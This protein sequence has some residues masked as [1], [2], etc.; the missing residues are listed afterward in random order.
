MPQFSFFHI[1]LSLLHLNYLFLKKYLLGVSV[2][3]SFRRFLPYN[4]KI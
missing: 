1:V 4:L 3:N 2:S